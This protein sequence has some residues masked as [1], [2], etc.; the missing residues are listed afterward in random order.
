MKT[1]VTQRSSKTPFVVF[2]VVMWVMFAGWLGW[3]YQSER[4]YAADY[5]RHLSSRSVIPTYQLGQPI[6][7]NS[8]NNVLFVDW[9]VEEPAFRWTLG[10]KSTLVFQLAE[11]LNPNASY[12]L[13]LRFAASIGMQTVSVLLNGTEI[14][15]T[16]VN[17]AQE[18]RC[19]AP[20]ATLKRG[21]N[22]IDLLVPNA[23]IPNTQDT[24]TLG[25]AFVDMVLDRAAIAQAAS[26]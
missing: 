16:V 12:P 15:K 9:S 14:H 18:L 4:E 8:K 19:A 26:R 24:R 20:G 1:V 3:I 23:Q 13:I 11:D 6:T 7:W 25:V 10:K 22:R 2:T 5:V 21:V 17:G